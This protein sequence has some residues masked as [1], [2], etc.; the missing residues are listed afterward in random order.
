MQNRLDNPW[1][2]LASDVLQKY[3][4]PEVIEQLTF[5]L[6]SLRPE[7]FKEEEIKKKKKFSNNI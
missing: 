2:Y 6:P 4:S 5:F 1:S 3:I 7:D